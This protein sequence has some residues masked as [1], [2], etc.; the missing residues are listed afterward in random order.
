[1]KVL[2][3][4]ADA[5]GVQ[6]GQS[7]KAAYKPCLPPCDLERDG[8]HELLALR[9]DPQQLVRTYSWQDQSR[10]WKLGRDISTAGNEAYLAQL[11]PMKTAACGDLDGDGRQEIVVNARS[12][13]F[14][15]SAAG[16]GAWT[17]TPVS[18]FGD[19]MKFDEVRLVDVNQDG[20]LNIVTTEEGH[21][22]RVAFGRGL[23][24]IWY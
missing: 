4:R 22:L 11:G 10:R 12:G 7:M 5:D 9:D 6:T 18:M 8:T 21:R 13:V 1:M 20:S 24:L 15:M 16:S 23:G 17:V 14:V 19:G 3:G 2:D